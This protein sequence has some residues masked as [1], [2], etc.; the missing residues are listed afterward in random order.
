M[1]LAQLAVFVR[2]PTSGTVKTRLA[3][4]FGEAGA[5]QLYQ[6]FVEDTVALCAR[7]RAAGRVDLALWAAGPDPIVSEWAER[8]GTSPRIQPEGDLGVRLSA[9]FDEGLRRYERVV[10][11]GS[12]MPTL[13]IELIGAAFES[14]EESSLMLGP[15][16]DGGY[17]AIG[18]SKGVQPG[19]E[20]VRWSTENALEDTVAANAPREPALIPPWYDI[21]VPEDLAVLRAH[22]SVDAAVAP[23]TSKCIAELDRA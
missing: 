22:L 12:D 2:P 13:P 19:F 9:A 17:Y 10:V 1:E 18:A 4:R 6:A 5:A 21:D 11:I 15:A 16:H 14:L 8:L 20:G 3:M 7:V 23:A